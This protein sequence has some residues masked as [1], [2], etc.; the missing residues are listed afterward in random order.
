MS[1]Y[2][3]QYGTITLPSA[4]G[5]GLKKVLRD[6]V[7]TLHD[8]VRTEAIRL[9]KEVAK[10]TRSTTLY[11]Q[12]L[13]AHDEQRWASERN[14]STGWYATPVRDEHKDL[15]AAMAR[16]VLDQMLSGG[17]GQPEPTP[18]QPTVADVDKVVAKATNRTVSFPIIGKDGYSEGN[19]TF[20]GR[21]VIW[22]VPENNHAVDD[23]NESEIGTKFWLAIERVKWTRGTG[24]SIWGNNEY[25]E[26]E[27]GHGRGPDYLCS[28][29]GPVGDDAQVDKYV[30]QGFTRKAAKEMV[31]AAKRP[32]R[33]SYASSYGRW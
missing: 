4:E 19:I 2:E 22:N 27:H 23:A 14:R 15:V 10:S 12:R 28:T 11:R 26:G 21:T 13:R 6:Y 20:D 16:Q 29:Y 24:G 18:H 7:N 9:H 31:A 3:W 30:T 8:E 17:W 25:N 32:Q 1:C 5:A 33:V